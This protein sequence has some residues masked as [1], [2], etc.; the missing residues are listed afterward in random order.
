MSQTS[1]EPKI[2]VD[3]DQPI[4]VTDT[5]PISP[6]G[7]SEVVGSSH[8]GHGKDG[9]A[10]WKRPDSHD[11]S[12]P[13]KHFVDDDKYLATCFSVSNSTATHKLDPKTGWSM[14]FKNDSHKVIFS[15]MQ[16][17]NKQSRIVLLD[18]PTLYAPNDVSFGEQ[19]SS[20]TFTAPPGS[21]PQE[22]TWAT[23]STP[24]VTIHYC[25]NGKCSPNPC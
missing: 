6:D 24:G 3:N 17:G 18:T 25:L 22:F 13:D 19:F 15:L 16:H 1:V 14:A 11:T 21:N 23:G 9:K 4:I 8:L 7:R 12:Y 10:T 20:M 2:R 5:T